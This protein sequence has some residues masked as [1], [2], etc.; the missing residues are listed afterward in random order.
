M[1][2]SEDIYSY[3]EMKDIILHSGWLGDPDKLSPYAK[4]FLP[5]LENL[6]YK[7]SI[8]Q[9]VDALP[10]SKGNLDLVDFLNTMV[11]LGF[12]VNNRIISLKKL[13]SRLTPCLFINSQFKQTYKNPLIINSK[14]GD[15]V[16]IF[17]PLNDETIEVDLSKENGYKGQ[18]YFFKSLTEVESDTETI[19]QS[20]PATPKLWV[21]N[22]FFRFKA[23]FIQIFVISVI[24]NI[25][26]MGSPLFV[27]YVYDKIIGSRAIDALVPV[28]IGA[29]LAVTL[30]GLLRIV[31][32]R[33]FSWFAVRVDTLVSKAIFERLLLFAPKY[34]ETAS[35]SSQINRMRDFDSVREFFG[36]SIGVTLFEVPFTLIYFIALTIIGGPLVIVPI[37]LVIAYAI[38]GWFINNKIDYNLETSA[39]AG[40]VKNTLLIETLTRLRSIRSMGAGDVW[41][42][43]F[44]MLSGSSSFQNFNQSQLTALLEGLAYGLSIVGGLATLTLGINLVWMGMITPGALIA[45]MMIIWKLITPFQTICISLGRIRNV[46]KSVEQVHRLLTIK[47]ETKIND[48]STGELEIQGDVEFNQVGLR[49]SNDVNPVLSGFNVKIAS[50]ECIGVTGPNGAGKSSLLKLISAM[51]NPQAGSVRIDG[52]DIRQVSPIEIRRS[53]AYIPQKASLYAGTISQNIRLS[54]PTASNDRIHFVLKK[55][56]ID[57]EINKLPGGLEFEIKTPDSLSFS[58]SF[59]ISMARAMIK[60]PNILLVDEIPPRILNSPFGKNI[61]DFIFSKKGKMTIIYISPRED[62]LEM[63]DKIIYLVGNGQAAFGTPDEILKHTA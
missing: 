62:I 55:L 53:I 25:F 28:V 22:I 7:G 16:E 63:A 27:M 39:K 6:E 47:S 50:G 56:G 52:V 61:L 31:K 1:K 13:D 49:Y 36:G 4:C 3:I 58:T 35:V 32:G 43:R 44:R 48:I 24:S 33:L 34:T 10:F 51:Y 2:V 5:I 42:D 46:W 26:A 37:L 11:N 60:T 59:L 45:S 54:D 15:I 40:T 14:N 41:F 18:A 38:L 12:K 23:L 21:K 9:F 20:I 57:E 19:T 8:R 17:D 30:D 29:L